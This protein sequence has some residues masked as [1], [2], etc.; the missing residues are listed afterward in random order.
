MFAEWACSLKVIAAASGL[1]AVAALS[2]LAALSTP[3]PSLL[4]AGPIT[5]VAVRSA[6]TLPTTPALS[7][8][9]VLE[10][11]AFAAL[12]VRLRHEQLAR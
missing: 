3:A 8:R 11:S 12:R 6:D 5:A 9:A 1:Y 2:V 10:L 7:Q 4:V